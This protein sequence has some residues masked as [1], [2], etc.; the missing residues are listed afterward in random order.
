[1]N[2]Y[3]LDIQ[4]NSIHDGP[5]MRTTVFLKGCPLRCAWCH[6]PESQKVEKE[7]SYRE[8]NCCKCGACIAVCQNDVHTM[9]DNIHQVNFLNCKA[10]GACEKVCKSDALSIVGERKSIDELMELII[11]DQPFYKESGGGITISGGEAL[12]HTDYVLELLKACRFEGIHTAI[13]TSG[14]VKKSSIEKILPYTD[15]FLYDY[16]VESQEMADTYIRGNLKLINDNLDYILSQEKEVI[17]RCPII[18]GVNDYEKHFQGIASYGKKWK[19]NLRV[20]LL[21]YHDYGVVKGK[22]VNIKQVKYTIPTDQ[23]VKKWEVY[24]RKYME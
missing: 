14:Y 7:L 13:E 10:C 9:E 11:K 5:G 8:H 2:T 20:E 16:K 12:I 22:N 4:R 1:M 19:N 21:P 23:D 6:N 15:L 3:I 18:P 24:L 17:L